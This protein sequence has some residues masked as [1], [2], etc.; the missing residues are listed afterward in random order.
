MFPSDYLT[1]I[2][3]SHY[4]HACDGEQLSLHCPRHSTISILSAFYGQS[5]ALICGPTGDVDESANRTCSSFTALQKLVAE[6]QGHRDCQLLVNKHVFGRDPCPGTAKLLH[7]SYKC[8]PTE[9]KKKVGCEGERM[10]LHCKHPRVLNIYSAIYGRTLGAEHACSSDN[11]EPPPFECLFHGAVDLVSK[12]CYAKQRCVI[13]VNDQNFRD[14]CYPG[15]RKYLSILYACG[16]APYPKGSR[17]PESSG[18]IVSNSLMAYAYVKEHPEMAALLFVSSMCVGLIC[19]LFAVSLRLSCRMV[20]GRG[21]SKAPSME[22]VGRSEGATE[23]EDSEDEEASSL[24][25]SDRKR[26]YC[27]E[28]TVDTVEA[29]ELA[30]RIER[31]EQVIQEIWMNAYLNGT[32]TG[33]R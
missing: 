14:P 13:T 4:V 2:I 5:E 15:I 9:H 18:V 25:C 10:K 31:R 3:Q 24:S 32:S 12:N 30:E 28:A 1:R 7:V 22:G 17:L 29:A 23:V 8:K 27:W 16:A 21:H 33:P 6:C 19:A 26:E 20:P 11:K